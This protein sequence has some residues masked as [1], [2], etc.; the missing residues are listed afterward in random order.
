VEAEDKVP[1]DYHEDD[2]ED[3]T[4]Q[5]RDLCDLTRLQIRSYVILKKGCMGP[6]MEIQTK[7]LFE[8]IC[9]V[10]NPLGTMGGMRLGEV[11]EEAAFLAHLNLSN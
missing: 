8:N 9:L 3:E 11:Y 1:E 4:I 2:T 5:E 6:E 10:C 7:H